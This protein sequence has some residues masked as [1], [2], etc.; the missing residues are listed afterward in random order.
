MRDQA[1]RSVEDVGISWAVQALQEEG[2][3][4]ER[5]WS[6]DRDRSRFPERIRRPDWTLD[7][8]A[9]PTAID[10]TLFAT[11][12][13]FSAS[14]RASRIRRAVT[15]RIVQRPDERSVLSLITF[16]TNLLL[17]RSRQQELDDI[18]AIIRAFDMVLDRVTEGVSLPLAKEA[19]PSWIRGASVTLHARD[20]ARRRV[21]VHL[22]PPVSPARVTALVDEFVS[23]IIESKGTQHVEWGRGVLVVLNAHGVTA[24][25]LRSGLERRPQVPWWRVYWIDPTPPA[26]LVWD[27][28]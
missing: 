13:W 14:A 10:V 27:A 24:T 4:I 6:P 28:S 2:R 25:D 15:G 7:V 19:L 3:L 23:S 17:N 16:D 20:E 11:T 12:P 22:V 26:I 8:D 1:N 5:E 9:L 21:D 18:E